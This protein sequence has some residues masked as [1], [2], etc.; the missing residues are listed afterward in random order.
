MANSKDVLWQVSAVPWPAGVWMDTVEGG[1]DQP[2]VS[3]SIGHDEVDDTGAGPA[4]TTVIHTGTQ[5]RIGQDGRTFWHS[6]FFMDD[7]LPSADEGSYKIG[8]AHV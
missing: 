5:K 2:D 4:C 7:R 1:F 8:R 6:T 3:V